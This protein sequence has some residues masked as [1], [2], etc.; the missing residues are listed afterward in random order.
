MRASPRV[1]R[2]VTLIVFALIVFGGLWW[3]SRKDIV[4]LADPVIWTGYTLFGM[5][6]FLFLFQSR[7]RLAMVPLGRAAHWT[8]LHAVGGLLGVG[9][10]WLH[11]GK[12]WPQGGYEQAL[13]ALFY[14]VSISGVIGYGMLIIYPKRLTQ[15]DVEVIYERIPGIIGDL[16]NAAEEVV[17]AC[18]RDT[19]SDTL[20][21]HY[22]ETFHWFFQRPRFF[23]SHV[24]DADLEDHWVRK[25]SAVVARYLDAAEKPYLDKLREIAHAKTKIDFNY[26]VQTVMKA[27]L[28]V[29]V[30]LA[31]ALMMLAIWHLIVVNV[32]AL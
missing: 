1:T 20:S 18:T 14:I 31:A 22:L 5:M 9:L 26:A 10:F 32:Y 11:M 27:W 4:S 24:V 7:K 6:V 15:R 30:P 21:R 29:H 25:Q 8:G 23:F 28:F 2:N 16:R 13:A 3:Q 17:L 19:G 12:L